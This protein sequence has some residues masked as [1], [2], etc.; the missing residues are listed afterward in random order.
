MHDDVWCGVVCRGGHITNTCA[1]Q[2]RKDFDESVAVRSLQELDGINGKL[3][4][5]C[6]A[7][8]L[9]VS[10]LSSVACAQG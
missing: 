3:P 1:Q 7:V 6:G 5:R 9:T 4:L 2:D 10:E 8:G